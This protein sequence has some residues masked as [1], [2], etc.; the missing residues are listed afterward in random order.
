MKFLL[1][2]KFL[3]T[4]CARLLK[5]REEESV[6]D[7]FLLTIEQLRDELTDLS[8]RLGRRADMPGEEGNLTDRLADLEVRGTAY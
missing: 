6:R 5:V 8:E 2:M 4:S 1:L 7:Q 3:L